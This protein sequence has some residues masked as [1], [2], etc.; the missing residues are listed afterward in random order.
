MRNV[1]KSWNMCSKI[2]QNVQ[3]RLKISKCFFLQTVLLQR[4]P[5]SM[6][7]KGTEISNNYVIS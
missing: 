5:N 4:F 1:G 6:N 7:A 3:K 2:L